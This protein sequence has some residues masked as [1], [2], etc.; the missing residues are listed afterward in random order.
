MMQSALY[1]H[2]VT[3]LQLVASPPQ[4]QFGF[5]P[6]GVTVTDEIALD[7]SDAFLQVQVLIDTHEITIEIAQAL[8][9]IEDE[10]RE[11]SLLPELWSQDALFLHDKWD[12]LRVNAMTILRSL[13]EEFEHPGQSQDT[14][15]F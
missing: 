2:L 11:M 9:T 4:M 13:G 14:Y 3:T 7:Y 10:F 12:N 8:Q 5:Y 1:K 15:I 6:H